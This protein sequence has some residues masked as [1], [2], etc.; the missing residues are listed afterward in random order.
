MDSVAEWGATSLTHLIL[1]ESGEGRTHNIS[2][3]LEANDSTL[4]SL[5]IRASDNLDWWRSRSP[6]PLCANA[7]PRLNRLVLAFKTEC[8]PTIRYFSALNNVKIVELGAGDEE[9]VAL[10]VP[11][12]RPSS[13]W[14]K[15]EEL[16]VTAYGDT[17]DWSDLYA[18]CDERGVELLPG[19]DVAADFPCTRP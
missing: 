16:S 13:V 10:M 17:G 8:I 6:P 18:M 4:E 19:F 9:T 5:A 1:A 11:L 14:P 12:L 7:L 3:L 15:L 2:A